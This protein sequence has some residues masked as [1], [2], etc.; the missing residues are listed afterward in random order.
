MASHCN[1]DRRLPPPAAAQCQDAGAP[2]GSVTGVSR[3]AP[4]SEEAP[5][6]SFPEALRITPSVSGPTGR[7]WVRHWAISWTT[8][9]SCLTATTF[10]SVVRVRLRRLS[11][12]QVCRPHVRL[13][14]ANGP[15]VPLWRGEYRRDS[16]LSRRSCLS[17]TMRG[18]FRSRPAIHIGGH[19]K[20]RWIW[21]CAYIPTPAT[22]LSA[23]RIGADA[24]NEDKFLSRLP[25]R[26]GVELT[27]LREGLMRLPI[28]W[29][30]CRRTPSS[31]CSRSR[32]MT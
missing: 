8:T 1:H 28:G 3:C 12:A 17:S 16:R 19:S 32:V 25:R 21:R 13:L 29:R 2:T 27:F 10:R 11:G 4:I 15:D 6:G 7:C 30:R 18:Q 22:C 23:R 31:F 24:R 5:G 26:R 14:I 20:S 9:P